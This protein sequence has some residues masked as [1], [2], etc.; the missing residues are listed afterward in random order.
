MG[1]RVGGRHHGVVAS[2]PFAL[3]ERT[4]P[5]RIVFGVLL[6]AAVGAMVAVATDGG[7]ST[8]VASDRDPAIE[9]LVPAPDADVLRQSQVGIDLVEGYRATLTVNGTPI[10]PD[11]IVGSADASSQPS[12]GLFLFAPGEGQV[13]ESLE[14]GL[15][16][17]SAEF[18]RAS[19]PNRTS[20]HSWCF[21]AA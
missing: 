12:L 17:V 8:R 4:V 19:D 13:L 6:V 5:R 16:C 20:I 3:L 11:Q 7:P 1:I 18:W 9:A 21:S 2:S 14:P 10:P 15:N